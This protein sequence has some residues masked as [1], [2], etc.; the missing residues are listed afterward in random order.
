MMFVV[1]VYILT[2]I[3]RKKTKIVI[4]SNPPSNLPDKN[5]IP[6]RSMTTNGY[7]S[8]LAPIGLDSISLVG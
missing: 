2:A 1:M 5:H 8:G 6:M 3:A 7:D 4:F